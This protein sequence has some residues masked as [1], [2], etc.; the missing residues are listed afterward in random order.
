MRIPFALVLLCGT[1]VGCAD[2]RTPDD[3]VADT[4]AVAAA[5]ADTIV[6]ADGRVF[7][8]AEDVSDWGGRPMLQAAF[9]AARAHWQAQDPDY[10]E[11]TQVM[12]VAEGS[13]SETG[14]SQYAILYLISSW[15]R[16]C[17]KMGIAVVQDGELVRNVAFEAPT[18]GLVA[19]PDLDGDGLDELALTGSF[20]M[21]GENSTS[22]TLVSL[23][24]SGLRTWGGEMIQ[25]DAC[26][27]MQEGGTASRITAV[28]GPAFT[29][30]RFARASC[31]SGQYEAGG[32]PEP[33][34]FTAPA[35][36]DEL[37][38]ELSI[39]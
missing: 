38:V 25:Y 10:E 17:P 31:E 12:S 16:C 19:V 29:I 1:V 18:Y 2:A 24:D 37:S 7:A 30:E 11:E 8:E 21:G 33:F 26:G 6:I 23:A 9:A 22:V 5:V 32:P 3:A 20:G 14:V 13:F 39:R 28:P 4:D 34:E 36:E 35:P 27:A 15:P